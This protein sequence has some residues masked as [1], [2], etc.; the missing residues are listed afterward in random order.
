M[1]TD[2]SSEYASA[3]EE[4]LPPLAEPSVPDEAGVAAPADESVR[5]QA[6]EAQRLLAVDDE[7]PMLK[8]LADV[9]EGEGYEVRTAKRAAAADQICRTWHPAVVIVDLVL[10]DLDGIELLRQLKSRQP[11]TEFV[12]LTGHG[13][14]P[15]AVEAM[16]AGAHSFVEK[17][18]DPTRLL[19][20][21][22]VALDR[23]ALSLE[24]RALRKELD[25]RFTFGDIIGKAA[26]MQEVFSLIQRV[27]PTDANVLIV[28]E[29]GVG[30]ELVANAIHASSRRANGPFV[31][32]NCASF[33]KELIESELFG[34]Q[35]GAF[36]GATTNR[37]GLLKAA[38]GGSLLLDEIGEMPA[39]LQ[40]RLLR[41]LQTREFRPV[42]SN[43]TETV[44]FRL[45]SATNADVETALRDGRLREDLYFRIN[46]ITLRVPP[47]RDRV[48][49]LPLLCQHF[50]EKFSTRHRRHITGIT[51]S[52][53][54]ALLHH[55][56]PGNVRELE[57]TIERGVLVTASSEIRPEDL[58]EQIGSTSRRA[59]TTDTALPNVTL[60]E[61]ERIA[62][63]QVLER[64]KG[65]KTEAA[66]QLGLYRQTLYSKIKKYGLEVRKT[67]EQAPH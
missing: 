10:P 16:Q 4:A 46:T 45:I 19:A 58:P 30:K 41:V 65:N 35:K 26:C 18:I 27:G 23:R 44:D 55:Q 48:E 12:V 29:S 9:L 66:Q 6:P 60:E 3:V 20:T 52:A 59:G 57:H 2:V 34:Y 28:G 49:D 25:R 54:E 7:A 40:T 22:R 13:S 43:Q 64:T 53:Y 56:W 51:P 5:S 1:P 67:V 33:P 39:N 31:K 15:K 42:G 21:L 37:S 8:W 61:L 11:E 36:T 47:L 63:I 32:I 38:S 24:N 14:I 62:L 17:P 50:L